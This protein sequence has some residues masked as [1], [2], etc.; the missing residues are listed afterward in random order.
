MGFQVGAR[1]CSAGELDEEGVRSVTDIPSG[2]PRVLI[3]EDEIELA[4]LLE[5]NLRRQGYAVSIAHDGLEACRLIGS[6]R[7]EL[8]LLD[9]LLP[10]LDGWEICRMV[11]SHH[12]EV[13]ARVPIIM[14]SA[15]GTAEDR[16]RGYDLG[17]DLYLPKPYSIKEVLLKVRALIDQ[18]RERLRLEQGMRSLQVLATR[19]DH[20][21]L[22]M[23]HELRNQLTVISL[24]AEQLSQDAKDQRP[25]EMAGY[26]G[27][28]VDNSQYLSTL[29]ENYL[30]VRRAEGEALALPQEEVVLV[31]LLDEVLSLFRSV[32]EQRG[33]ALK[34]NC[35]TDVTLSL[36]PAG[37]KIIVSTLLDNALKYS[38]DAAP[39]TLSAEQEQER[40]LI[41]VHNGGAKIPAAER[42]QI[43]QRFYRG[44]QARSQ[45][46]GSGL[47]LYMA[48][49]LAHS[50]G[51]D[52]VLEDEVGA[53][54]CFLLTL[55]LA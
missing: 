22:A 4:D 5:F 50:M 28:I 21:Q 46:P 55:P 32:A 3:V 35:P 20:W 49:T 39:V 7:P 26:A 17:A 6:E 16:I 38:P 10:L 40:V 24:M 13:I 2:Q 43:F 11:R 19:K 25:A 8:I 34:L 36:H 30:F 18:R 48:K 31:K 14:L 47:G 15:L 41:R 45:E 54:T 37:V 29:A 52:L 33:C 27:Q 12:D 42:G 1:C 53:G 9:L 44:S 51:G 23:F